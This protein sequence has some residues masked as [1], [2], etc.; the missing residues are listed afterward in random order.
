MAVVTERMNFRA[1]RAAVAG[2]SEIVKEREEDELGRLWLG[3]QLLVTVPDSQ[4]RSEMSLCVGVC[5][6]GS[7][8]ALS[9]WHFLLSETTLA[10]VNI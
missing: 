1:E 5:I 8:A 3:A 2:V 9:T 7:Q 6:C 4:Q 10:S